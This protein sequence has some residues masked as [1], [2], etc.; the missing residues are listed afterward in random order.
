MQNLKQNA[1]TQNNAEI[2]KQIPDYVQWI[3]QIL[4]EHG[5]E[6]GSFVKVHIAPAKTAGSFKIIL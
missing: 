6:V 2:R 3:L 5:F 4:E 1:D